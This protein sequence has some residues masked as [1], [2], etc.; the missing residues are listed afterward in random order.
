MTGRKEKRGHLKADTGLRTFL[1]LGKI[2]KY[3]W[4]PGEG[5]SRIGDVAVTR[6]KREL[7]QLESKR[8]NSRAK[9]EKLALKRREISEED[10]KGESRPTYN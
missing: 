2:I 1:Q 10:G 3:F 4:V 7:V 6:K 9:V 8:M 5:A